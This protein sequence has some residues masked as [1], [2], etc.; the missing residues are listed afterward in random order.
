MT[1]LRRAYTSAAT[2]CPPSTSRRPP[3]KANPSSAKSLTGGTN[4]SFPLNQGLT[5]C[6]SDETTSVRWPGCKERTW[7]SINSAAPRKKP[8]RR[9][10]RHELFYAGKRERFRKDHCAEV[11][12]A[13]ILPLPARRHTRGNFRD[14]AQIP[15][16]AWRRVRHRDSHEG[17]YAWNHSSRVASWGEECV[18][19]RCSRWRARA[20]ADMTVPIG[21]AVMEAISL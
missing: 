11:T 18:S 3:I 21:M 9:Q 2:F 15:R 4:A 7:A 8:S 6:W 10:D 1:C 13:A 20:S 16:R 19:A 17:R 5:V 12:I 14:G